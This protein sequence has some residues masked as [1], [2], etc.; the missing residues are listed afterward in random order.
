MYGW[1]IAIILDLLFLAG[2]VKGNPS[3]LSFNMFA[4]ECFCAHWIVMGTCTSICWF[5]SAIRWLCSNWSHW[6][7]ERRLNSEARLF[8]E[9]TQKNGKDKDYVAKWLQEMR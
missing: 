7:E 8:M 4:I 9:F 3:N 6:K 2:Y 5:L 1:T